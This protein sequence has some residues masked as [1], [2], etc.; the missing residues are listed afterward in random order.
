MALTR[1]V[2]AE[3][4]AVHVSKPETRRAELAAMLRFAGSLHLVGGK[5]VVE[6]E[7]DIG[8]AA[9]RVRKTIADLYGFDS[10]LVVINPAGIRKN[11]RYVIRMIKNG[12]DL[13]RLIGLIDSRGFPVRGMPPQIV[14][15]GIREQVAAWRGAF[16]ARGSLTEPGRS[17]SLEITCPS[18]E[19][20]L[21]MVGSA[22]RLDVI[23]KA[24]QSRGVDKVVIKDG[25]AISGLLA[26]MGA[27]DAVLVWEERRIRREVKASATRLANFDDANLRR[28][29][30]AAVAASARVNR[31]LE[32]LGDDIPAHL[33]AAGK[34]RLANKQA[35][36]EELGQLHEP[37]ITKDAIAGRIRRLL[38][39]ADK[40]ASEQGIPDTKSAL[41]QIADQ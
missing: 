26:R 27:H 25:D 39:M 4:A 35:S 37:P 14:G 38:A 12:R 20:A 8:A 7:F 31:A 15:G 36:L 6:A 30:K 13:A 18:S 32:I 2:K 10:D 40:A 21:A 17:M 3:L 5:I 33:L 28:S 1:Q 34:L 29:A 23:A 22:R 9:R 16:L 24:R 41:Q 19:S 11:S